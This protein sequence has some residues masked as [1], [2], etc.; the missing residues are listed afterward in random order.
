MKADTF[1][2][3]LRKVIREEVQAVVREELGI[4]LET[5][6]PKPVVTEI[7]N[8]S[9]K[10]SMIE[11]IKSTTPTQPL[12]FTNNGILN[13]ILNDTKNSGEWRTIADMTSSDVIGFGGNE[14][15][16]LEPT[17]VNSVDQMLANTRPAGDI[18]AVRIDVVPD[19][20]GLV[21]KMKENGQL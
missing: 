14:F 20:T 12:A 7:K 13:E 10:N 16:S 3:I 9:I 21:S 19:F 8:T 15:N 2:K 6:E 11:S 1:I 18:N 4:L 17:V 5:P